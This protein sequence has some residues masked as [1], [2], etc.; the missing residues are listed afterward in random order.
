[1]AKKENT[2]LQQCSQEDSGV[3][4]LGWGRV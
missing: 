1:L 2:Y 3:Y 4:F